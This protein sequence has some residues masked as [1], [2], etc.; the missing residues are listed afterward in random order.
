MKS[1]LTIFWRRL[2]GLRLYILAEKLKNFQKAKIYPVF[3]F[4]LDRN[5]IRLSVKSQF[6]D[7]FPRKSVIL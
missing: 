4:V 2:Q 3:L 5:I 1:I 7:F 6:P